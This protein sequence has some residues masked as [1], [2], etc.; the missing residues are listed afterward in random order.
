MLELLR[1][2]PESKIVIASGYAVDGPIQKTLEQ[3]AA[4]FIG[5]PYHMEDM[6]RTVRRILNESP[7]IQSASPR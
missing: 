4:G 6:L 7:P 3:G 2:A 1:I 5:K